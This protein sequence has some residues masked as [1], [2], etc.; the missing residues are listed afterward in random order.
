MDRSSGSCIG[1]CRTDPARSGAQSFSTA[2]SERVPAAPAGPAR[3][4]ADPDLTLSSSQLHPNY[5]P[6]LGNSG[7]TRPHQKLD[8]TCPFA[9]ADDRLD[10]PSGTCKAD[11]VGSNPTSGSSVMSQ[12]VMAI[13]VVRTG[14]FDPIR[15][16]SR[17]VDATTEL[18]LLAI[19]E[20]RVSGSA[21]VAVPGG[22]FL[23]G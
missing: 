19:S 10:R 13:D 21:K 22:V 11:V 15:T 18:L 3:W 9:T 23:G 5:G 12:V 1:A 14:E 4:I 17:F 16:S 7:W 6:I 20:S 8:L 2:L